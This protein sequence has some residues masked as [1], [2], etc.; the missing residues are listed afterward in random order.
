MLMAT[1]ESHICNYVAVI[2]FL[3]VSFIH[4]RVWRYVVSLTDMLKFL[5]NF[6]TYLIVLGFVTDLLK[7]YLM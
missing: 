2:I 6:V 7:M 5:R 4:V 3:I 1:A